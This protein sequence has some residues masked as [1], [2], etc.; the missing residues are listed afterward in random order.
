[1]LAIE[2]TIKNEKAYK[3]AELALELLV[4]ALQ[5]KGIGAK[6]SAGYGYLY[7]VKDKNK[8]V[9]ETKI[10]QQKEYKSGDVV[11][12]KRVEDPKGKGR[13][14]FSL[15]DGS[16]SGR[17]IVEGIP[18]VELG[19]EMELRISSC[20]MNQKSANFTLK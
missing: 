16:L 5:E 15:L 7:E 17:L 18:D 3:W 6:T 13:P 20:N 8:N 10:V 1:M 4:E 12:V 11:V 2:P 9:P 19:T 14:W